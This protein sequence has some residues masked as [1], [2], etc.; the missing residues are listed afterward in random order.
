MFRN[1]N[2]NSEITMLSKEA[3]TILDKFFVKQKPQNLL[4]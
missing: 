1:Q 2:V 3:Q 4:E